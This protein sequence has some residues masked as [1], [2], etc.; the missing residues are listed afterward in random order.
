M[1]WA[2]SEKKTIFCVVTR[3]SF[4]ETYGLR[5][6]DRVT[7]IDFGKC[8]NLHTFVPFWQEFPRIVKEQVID[9]EWFLF[10]EQDIWFYQK[11]KHDPPPDASEIRSHLPLDTAYHAVL[12]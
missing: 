11:I 8:D 1:K 6:D 7:Y 5:N 3:G 9:P 10:M 2:L 4:I 12:L